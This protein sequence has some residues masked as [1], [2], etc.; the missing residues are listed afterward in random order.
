MQSI[1]AKGAYAKS[2][3]LLG[4][5]AYEVG[6]DYKGMLIDAARAGAGLATSH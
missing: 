5:C 6:G 3:G 4:F 1:K 2:A